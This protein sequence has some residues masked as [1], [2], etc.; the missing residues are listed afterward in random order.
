M[1]QASR[2]SPMTGAAFRVF[3]NRKTCCDCKLNIRAVPVDINRITAAESRLSA[4]KWS[5]IMTRGE[6]CST[7]VDKYSAVPAISSTHAAIQP[8]R[9]DGAIATGGRRDKPTAATPT[10]VIT[11]RARSN[12]PAMISVLTVRRTAFSSLPPPRATSSYPSI[13]EC[14]ALGSNE[15]HLSDRSGKLWLCRMIGMCW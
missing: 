5:G 8:R 7:P 6:A 10:E 1:Q 15:L 12:N 14:A 13:I 4:S 2:C 9:R 11:N 3:C